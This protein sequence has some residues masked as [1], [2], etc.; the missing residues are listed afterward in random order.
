MQYRI[1]GTSNL[2]VSALAFGAWQIGDP[3]YWGEGDAHDAQAVVDAALDAGITLFDTA[4]MYGKGESE[5]ALGKALG[6]RRKDVLVASKVWPDKCAPADLRRACEGS[7]ERLGTDYLDLYQI[8]WPVRGIPFSDVYGELDR[9]KQEGKIREIGVSNFGVQDLDTWMTAGTCVSD[10]LG[11]NLLFRAVEWEILPAC[12]RHGIGVLVY[13]PLLQG[14][15]T[16]RW[17]TAEEVPMLRRRTRHFSSHRE[18][19][20]HGEAGCEALTFGT[21]AKVA[22]VADGV[23]VPMASLA[24]AWLLANPSVSSVIVGGRHP[25]QL[26]RN[27]DAAGMTLTQ[28]VRAELD[29]ITEPLKA[30]LGSNADMWL[31]AEDS[32]IR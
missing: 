20:R 23:G 5:R 16:G 24:L 14:L 25:E 7:L 8:H 17:H 31:S 29:F 11:Y 10:Q 3:A 2:K 13:M 18:G 9:L 27:L 15:L 6:A 1:L 22:R 21:L 28:D 12:A 26:R 30:Q 32:R 4:E 19:T